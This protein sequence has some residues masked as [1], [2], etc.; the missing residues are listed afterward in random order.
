MFGVR[1]DLRTPRGAPARVALQARA[2]AH[3]REISA[4]AAGFAFVAFGAGFGAFFRR[5]LLGVGARVGPVHLLQRLRRREFLLGLA[6]ERG[7]AGDFR[8]RAGGGERGDVG[9]S[10]TPAGFAGRPSP[11]RG[12]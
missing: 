11:C 4:L 6:L 2:V 8:A 1:H 3:Q 12:G 10:P 5:G 9:S 7:G